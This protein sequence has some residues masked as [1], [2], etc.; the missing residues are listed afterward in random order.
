L[1]RRWCDFPT[2]LDALRLP[3]FV[4]SGLDGRRYSFDRCEEFGVVR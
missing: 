3:R 4:G 2:S 1:G